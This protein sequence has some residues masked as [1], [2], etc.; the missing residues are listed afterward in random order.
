LQNRAFGPRPP[1]PCCPEDA[2]TPITVPPWRHCSAS[3][4]LVTAS[5]GAA[6]PRPRPR[7][8][9]PRGARLHPSLAW[10]RSKRVTPRR[11]LPSLDREPAHGICV[12]I[13][14]SPSLKPRPPQQPGDRQL[15][16][17]CAPSQGPCRGSPRPH[18][19]AYPDVPAHPVLPVARRVRHGQRRARPRRHR[20][21]ASPLP[22]PCLPSARSSSHW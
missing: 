9:A 15:R 13:T 12:T 6:P 22:Q 2:P 19:P 1:W 21:T 5:V 4:R 18:Q 11:T 10:R 3:A 14:T 17:P 20:V 16:R 8:Q 7:H